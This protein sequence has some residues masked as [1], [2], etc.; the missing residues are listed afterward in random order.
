MLKKFSA[1]D[2]K[3][4]SS[5]IFRNNILLT[6]IGNIPTSLTTLVFDNCDSVETLNLSNMEKLQDDG[7]VLGEMKNLKNFTYSH[8]TSKEYPSG[9]T[10]LNFTSCPNIETIKAICAFA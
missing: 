4:L 7:I 5:L 2:C 10:K 9:I 6:D 3:N 1:L 8:K